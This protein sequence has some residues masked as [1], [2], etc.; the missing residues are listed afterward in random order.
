MEFEVETE[1]KDVR[2]L[3]TP[4]SSSGKLSVRRGGSTENHTALAVTMK[5]KVSIVFYLATSST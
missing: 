4:S 1:I 2:I 3:W 5:E